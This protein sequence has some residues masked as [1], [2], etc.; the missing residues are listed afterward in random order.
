MSTKLLPWRHPQ[1]SKS[2]SRNKARWL[3]GHNS[4]KNLSENAQYQTYPRF[5]KTCFPVIHWEILNE[6]ECNGIF[7]IHFFG[8]KVRL[9]LIW[10]LHKDHP[11]IWY[12]DEYNWHGSVGV[13]IGECETPTE[14]YTIV[15]MEVCYQQIGLW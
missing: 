4:H 14:V 1:R 8:W 7:Y 5:C 13:N 3:R 10:K 2:E 15:P 11:V 9:K 6:T 12:L